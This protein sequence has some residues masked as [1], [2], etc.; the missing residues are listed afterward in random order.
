M[1]R[2]EEIRNS[3]KQVLK[4]HLGKDS[5]SAFIFGSQANKKQLIHAD[6][7]IGIEK[8]EISPKELFLIKQELEALD[9]LYPIDLVDFEH[10][11]NE[12]RKIARQNVEPL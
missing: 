3:I 7:D 12:F 6:I 4:R 10:C 9:I 5:F 8:E 11:S 1:T 2:K